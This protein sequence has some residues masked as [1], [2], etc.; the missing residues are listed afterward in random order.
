MIRIK[1]LMTGNEYNF[2]Q[3]VLSIGRKRENDITV[4]VPGTA[5]RSADYKPASMVSRLH[6]ELA[7][8]EDGV[9]LKDAGSEYGTFVTSHDAR[10][11]CSARKLTAG[12]EEKLNKGDIFTLFWY[13][14][15]LL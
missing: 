1:D 9:Y 2:G 15:Q 11:E 13:Q 10:G 5:W 3:D 8:R 7:R 12:T 14:M 4:P 6:A